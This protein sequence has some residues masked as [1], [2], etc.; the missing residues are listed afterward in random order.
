MKRGAPAPRPR[1]GWVPED[2]RHTVRLVVRC[3]EELAERARRLPVTLAEVLEAG[4][5]K[6]EK[7]RLVS[8]RFVRAGCV[9]RVG[10][11]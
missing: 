4:V 10:A 11:W 9:E 5:E 3:S 6:L 8:R 1:S 2:A 7:R